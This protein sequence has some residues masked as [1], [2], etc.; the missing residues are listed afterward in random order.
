LHPSLHDC[1]RCFF[2]NILCYHPRRFLR[3]EPFNHPKYFKQ[4]IK[5]EIAHNPAKGF[6]KLQALLRAVLL[7]R[8]KGSKIGGQPIIALPE[9]RQ[10]L[11]KIEFSRD[12]SAFYK[13]VTRIPGGLGGGC[14]RQVCCRA[15]GLTKAARLTSIIAL[16][17]PRQLLLLKIKFSRDES[18]FYKQV[19]P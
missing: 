10:T 15:L 18:A 14:G 4:H 3:Y 7:R 5:E 1:L 19:T 12:E 6:R 2:S 17:E 9:R 8:T 11:L 13:Q 16:P